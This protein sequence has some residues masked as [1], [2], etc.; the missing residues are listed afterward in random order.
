MTLTLPLSLLISTGCLTGN[1][2]AMLRVEEALR[3]AERH[4]EVTELAARYAC[5]QVREQA[6]RDECDAAADTAGATVDAA[7]QLALDA[8]VR[9]W[10]LRQSGDDASRAAY[11]D[12]RGAVQAAVSLAGAQ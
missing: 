7:L 9:Y 12:A 4:A 6:K 8:L 10:A 1:D 5:A 3:T 11:E 2:A